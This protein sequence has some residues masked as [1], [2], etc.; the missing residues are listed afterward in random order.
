MTTIKEQHFYRFVREDSITRCVIKE[1]F[2]FK[3][4][5]L[6]S[7]WFHRDIQCLRVFSIDSLTRSFVFYQWP[8]KSAGHEA[9]EK[10]ES[11]S[12]ANR[13]IVLFK[14]KAYAFALHVNY[15]DS[16]CTVIAD[17]WI[18]ESGQFST[19]IMYFFNISCYRSANTGN[20]ATTD[21]TRFVQLNVCLNFSQDPS[22]NS[23]IDIAI[24]QTAFFREFFLITSRSIT[25]FQQQIPLPF[26]K[27]RK[28]ESRTTNEYTR[29]PAFLSSEKRFFR[30]SSWS[31]CVA[32][33]DTSDE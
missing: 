5:R 14:R 15:I 26:I 21:R 13:S 11:F 2:R 1:T 19:P 30:N 25:K 24:P 4:S 12:F 28:N 20:L 9:N 33:R 10:E 3:R 8:T 31:R 22:E 7:H 18:R 29:W 32:L 27:Q 17:K 23:M 6:F 16:V